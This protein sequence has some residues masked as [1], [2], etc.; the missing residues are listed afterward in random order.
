VVGK[1]LCEKSYV[2]LYTKRKDKARETP[3]TDACNADIAGIANIADTAG[4]GEGTKRRRGET[5]RRHG[6]SNLE[7]RILKD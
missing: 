1:P 6:I 2:I 4:D 5:A 7:A 3:G